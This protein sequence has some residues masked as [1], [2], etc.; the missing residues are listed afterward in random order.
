MINLF[1]IDNHQINTKNFSSL[2]H[3]QIVNDFE[4]T[5]CEYVGAKYGVS[6]NSATNAIF[7]SLLNKQTTIRIPSIIPPVVPNA[8]ITSNNKIEFYDDIDWVGNSYVLHRFENYKIVD[9]AQKLEKNQFVNEC[10]HDDLMIFSFYPTKPIGSCD[11]GL[12][13]SNDKS[14]I[15]Y[16]KEM[17]LNGMSYAENNWDRKIK[18]VGYKMYMNSLQ[19]S[20]AMNNFVSYKSKLEKLDNIRNFYNSEFELAN[21]S[22]HL[23][24]LNV[25]NNK[26]FIDNMKNCGIMCG[27]HYEALH[28]NRIY[29]NDDINLPLSEKESFST[30]SIPYHEKLTPDELKHIVKCVHE[31]K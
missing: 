29:Q 28:L 25:T 1:H 26:K 4:N 9:S 2:L 18:F 21:T 3:D 5:I 31:Y 16:L 27:I 30:V 7:L 15:Q 8:I 24:R 10:D 11:G 12:I 13:V 19:A 23:Y 17:S 6:L 14:K 22:N 20:I